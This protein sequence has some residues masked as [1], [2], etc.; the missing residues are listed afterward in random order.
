M[1]CGGDCTTHGTERKRCSHEGCA[2]GAV[3]G[4]VCWRHS[5]KKLKM[6]RC[7]HDG[8]TNQYRWGEV[9]MRHGAKAKVECPRQPSEGNNVMMTVSAIARGDR[10]I[11]ACNL[12]TD[13]SLV[14]A[15]QSPTLH[16]SATATNLSNEEEIG[17]W[18]TS[19]VALQDTKPRPRVPFPEGTRKL[20]CA[21]PK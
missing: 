6:K 11:G 12:Q 19:P 15:C 13:I 2:N 17:A 20:V 9:C 14:A 8:Y 5:A 7:S 21:T 4:Q 10:K 1:K 18:F 16:P 3:N